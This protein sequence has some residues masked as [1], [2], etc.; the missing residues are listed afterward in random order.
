MITSGKR[1]PV[2]VRASLSQWSFAKTET[3]AIRPRYWP[4]PPSSAIAMS[5]LFF[6]AENHAPESRK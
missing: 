1:R 2:I 6:Q 3:G 5:S 4:I